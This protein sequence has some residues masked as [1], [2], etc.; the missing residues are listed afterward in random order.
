M[1]ENKL[2]TK[3]QAAIRA[4]HSLAKRWP[5]TLWMFAGEGLSIM[6]TGHDG[7]RVSRPDGSYDPDFRVAKIAIPS[8]GGAW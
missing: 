1:T 2:T 6:R 8:D 4:L 5:S 7:Q 3:E